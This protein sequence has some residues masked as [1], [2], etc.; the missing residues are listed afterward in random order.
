M[1]CP[2]CGKKK[3]SWHRHHK[4]HNVTWA[5]KLYGNLMDHPKNIQIVC[6][7]CNTSH[8]GTGLTHW[9]ERE[10]CTALCIGM[11]SKI[12]KSEEI[13]TGNI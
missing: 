1:I 7:D 10:F 8:A 3:T 6:A 13:F 9:S 2:A 12:G 11:R 5:R 4:F